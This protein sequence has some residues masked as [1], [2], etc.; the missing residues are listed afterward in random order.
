MIGKPKPLGSPLP[1]RRSQLSAVVVGAV[2]AAVVLLP[3]ALRL[4]GVD[5]QLVDAL[6]D[7]RERVVR[8][9]V[10]RHAGVGRLPRLA[11]VLGAEGPRRRRSRR[12]SAVRVVRVELDGVAAHPARARV[13]LLPG[14]VPDEALHGLPRAPESSL[15]KRTPG[16]P[17]SQRRP[18][19]PSRPG[20]TCQ[21]FSS[22]RPALLGEAELL[23]ARPRLAA[24]GRAVDGRAV[25]EAVRGGVDR[26]VTR[27]GNGVE[28][29]P[30]R[31]QRVGDLPVAAVLVGGED[32]EAL[33]RADEEG[34]HIRARA[35]S[36]FSTIVNALVAIAGTRVPK[37]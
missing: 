35:P 6:A 37:G 30:A 16:A 14:L 13:P 31:Q 24:I 20:R 4:R 17:P 11:A 2:H 8:E 12:T 36:P 19:S 25:D 29:L 1:S 33:P 10:G 7:L 9:E 3:E 28:D 32:E 34:G 15:R 23:G 5:E 26:A 21:V 27:V 18:F 22:V